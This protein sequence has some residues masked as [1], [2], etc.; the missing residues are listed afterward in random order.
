MIGIW[1]AMLSQNRAKFKKA[2]SPAAFRELY[3]DVQRR[4]TAMHPSN[5]GNLGVDAWGNELGSSGPSSSQ[6]SRSARKKVVKKHSRV[7][8]L[9]KSA[10]KHSKGASLLTRDSP[11]ATLT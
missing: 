5:K 2:M 10:T 4:L 8:N 1:G 6:K 7:R 9:P 11:K 3:G